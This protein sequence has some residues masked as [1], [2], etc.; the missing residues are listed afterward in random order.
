MKIL[1]ISPLDKDATVSIVED[2]K[3][4]YAAGEER[5]TRVKQQSGFPHKALENA[6]EYTNTSINEID[7]IAYA[8]TDAQ[9]EKKIIDKNI[10][11]EEQFIDEFKPDGFRID[12]VKHV[13]MEF[14]QAFSPALMAHAK[15]Q[16][17]DNFFMYGEVYSFEPEFLS[18]YS[19]QGK[20]PSILDFALQKSLENTLVEQQ[21]TDVLAK[22]FVQDHFCM[23][24]NH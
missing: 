13:N 7:H 8:F 18:R 12:T 1:G 2:G 16:G 3:I 10:A 19:T 20:I 21:G 6:L 17:I 23:N 14:W 15:T 9:D 11:S 4:L 22:L 5:F 24:L